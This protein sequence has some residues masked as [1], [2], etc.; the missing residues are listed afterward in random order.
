MKVLHLRDGLKNGPRGAE[1]IHER[2]FTLVELLVVLAVV[3]LGAVMLL[4]AQAGT[5]TNA[6]AVQC[7]NNLRQL[8]AAFGM[9]SSDFS[10]VVV[11]NEGGLNGS[12]WASGWE[13]WGSGISPTGANTNQVILLTGLLGPYT[14]A[15]SLYKCPADVMPSVIGPRVR[16]YSMNGFAGGTSEQTIY[17]YTTYRIYLKTSDFTVPGPAQ[18]FVFLDEHPDSINDGTFSMHMPAVGSWPAATT[19]DDLPASYHSDAGCLSFADG[20]VEL[21]QWRDAATKSPVLKVSPAYG[22]GQTSMNDS[23]WLVARTTAPK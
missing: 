14:R 22:V 1:Q 23:A 16:S 20:H 13:N 4:P 15:A 19:W 10:G 12:G 21:H 11:S 8:Q 3:V 18:T 9:Y 5:K 2:A 7:Q 17:G 6:A